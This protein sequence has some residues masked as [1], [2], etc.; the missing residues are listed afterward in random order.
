MSCGDASIPSFVL[1]ALGMLDQKYVKMIDDAVFMCSIREYLVDDMLIG[2]YRELVASRLATALGFMSTAIMTI[3]VAYQGFMIISGANRQPI[4]PL[5]YKSAKMVLI[6]SLVSLA[7]AQSPWM[8]DTVLNFQALITAAIVGEGSDVYQII[9]INLAMG[10]VFNAL[11]DGLVGGQQASADGKHLTSMAGLVG[12]SGPAML[13]SVLALMAEISITLSIM[14][15]PLFI[16]FLLFQLTAPMFWTWAK[17]LL[18]TMVSLAV[19]TLIS[20]VL[21]KMMMFYGA[22][23]LAAFYVNGALGSILSIDIAGSAVRMATMGGLS[24]ALLMLVPPLIMQFFNSGAS[25]AASALSGSGAVEKMTGQAAAGGASAGAGGG[26][27][28]LGNNAGGGAEPNMAAANNRMALQHVNRTEAMGSGGSANAIGAEMPRGAIGRAATSGTGTQSAGF[29]RAQAQTMEL[30]NEAQVYR[31]TQANPRLGMG[32]EL[33]VSGGQT[34]ASQRTETR[35][36]S[37]TYSGPSSPASTSTAETGDRPLSSNTQGILAKANA[38]TPAPGATASS[39]TTSP[40][41][42]PGP[43]ATP[44]HASG[45]AAHGEAVVRTQPRTAGGMHG[46]AQTR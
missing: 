17:F 20:G 40:A 23:V 45:P 43:S 41:G 6:L 31:A 7:A 2:Y 13:V 46:R 33:G 42:S 27:P 19:L 10:Q 37:T 21:L 5:M 25:F 29:Q 44:V 38:P 36:S 39:A 26:N 8:A 18:G 3:W 14:L 28:A 1:T 22:A 4:V 35:Q 9:D 34:E 32:G 15:A 30:D 16:F 24:S 12:Q 11:V